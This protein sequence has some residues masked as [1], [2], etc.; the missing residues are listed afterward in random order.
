MRFELAAVEQQ[1]H[2]VRVVHP[3][4]AAPAVAVVPLADALAIKAGQF[5]SEHGV[6]VA[7]SISA[8][9]RV[10]AVQGDVGEIV[11]VREDAHLAELAHSR[12]QREPDVSVVGLDHAVQAAQVVAV[13]ECCFRSAQYVQDRFVVLV[14]Q[15][16]D[17]SP[18]LPV[19]GFQQVREAAGRGQVFGRHSQSSLGG[20]ELLHDVGFQQAGLS[21]AA[22]AEVEPHHRVA[23][24]PVPAVVDMEPF[25]QGFVALEQL[26][27]R[28]QQQALAEP[29]RARQEVV[30]ASVEQP[31]D[32]GCLV[33]VVAVL[34]AHL[35]EGLHAD[36]QSAPAHAPILPPRAAA[37]K[38]RGRA[39]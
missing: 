39:A 1:Q 31:L 22:A 27:D 3:L 29:A 33:D 24:R 16:H 26:L 8:D 14:H 35:A 15:H 7:L 5:R 20:G 18:R 4:L 13:G 17:S 32:A 25:E 30:L 23:F 12:H 34:L 11:Q 36:R 19:Q 21:E 9:R 37:R 6:H 2:V 10:A 38:R 28:V